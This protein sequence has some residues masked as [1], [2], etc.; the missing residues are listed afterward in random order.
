MD[1][2]T[3]STKVTT[4][5]AAKTRHPQDCQHGWRHCGKTAICVVIA[6]SLHK[7]QLEVSLGW[8]CCIC[9]WGPLSPYQQ[10]SGGN[11]ALILTNLTQTTVLAEPE[12]QS[13]SKSPVKQVFLAYLPVLG[14][15]WMLSQTRSPLQSLL[16]SSTGASADF[17]QISL[18]CVLTF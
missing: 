17:S 15:F 18:N 7:K 6:L 5:S 4:V 14:Y 11:T 9:I 10:G 3:K 1:P 13:A 16:S 12:T 2:H 8:H